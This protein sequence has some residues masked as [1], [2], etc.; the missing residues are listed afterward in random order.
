MYTKMAGAD[1]TRPPDL[2]L[3]ELHNVHFVL[4]AQ[5]PSFRHLESIVLH[6]SGIEHSIEYTSSWATTIWPAVRRMDLS[7]TAVYQL[8]EGSSR[9]SL[10]STGFLK[11]LDYLKLNFD[12]VQALSRGVIDLGALDESVPIL[13][14]V[15]VHHDIELLAVLDRPPMVDLNH[16]LVQVSYYR[17]EPVLKPDSIAKPLH[18]LRRL[19]AKQRAPRIVFIP[20]ALWPETL[21]DLFWEVV[22]EALELD[23]YVVERGVDVV[24]YPLVDDDVARCFTD[25]MRERAAA[26]AAAARS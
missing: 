1:R 8:A 19:I 15:E 26:R 12:D 7:G 22:D 11:Q 9:P 2:R 5:V 14:V 21:D 16:I 10:L 24:L 20:D 3:L 25:F 23:A 4:A 6:D 13:W 18:K 17:N